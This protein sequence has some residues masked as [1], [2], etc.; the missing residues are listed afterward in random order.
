MKHRFRLGASALFACIRKP[1]KTHRI[2]DVRSDA[3]TQNET[4]LLFKTCF[5]KRRKNH[6][7]RDVHSDAQTPQERFAADVRGANP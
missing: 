6:R 2:R 5:R 1:R 3:Q 4:E 7:I